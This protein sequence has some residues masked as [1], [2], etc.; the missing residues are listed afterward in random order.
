MQASG[1]SGFAD[2][3]GTS[4]KFRYPR[5]VITDGTNVYVADSSN[6]K[7]RKIVISTGAVTTLAGTGN[8]G[9]TD[10]V[11]T[12]AQFKSVFDITIHGG[13]LYVPGHGNHR[14]RKI[15]LREL[16]TENITMHNLDDDVNVKVRCFK[17]QYL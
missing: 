1:I 13:N 11:G 7:I 14:I 3:T 16:G 12:S 8:S 10:G 4:A 9:F 6:N 5:G 17:Q 15:A 2:G